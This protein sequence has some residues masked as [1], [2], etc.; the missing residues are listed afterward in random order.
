M[1]MGYPICVKTIRCGSSRTGEGGKC[2]NQATTSQKT[3]TPNEKKK[4]KTTVVSRIAPANPGDWS[5]QTEKC[6]L[7][8]DRCNLATKA[9]SNRRLVANKSAPGLL[10]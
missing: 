5:L 4:P 8:N 7:L 6:L 9:S 10:D 1:E 2:K 3:I